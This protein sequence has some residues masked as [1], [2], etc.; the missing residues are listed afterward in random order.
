V[1]HD[2]KASQLEQNS[3]L[4]K[5]KSGP[6]PA[7]ILG[8]LAGEHAAVRSV[9]LLRQ[10]LIMQEIPVGQ[11]HLDA[12][13]LV[14]VLLAQITAQRPQTL[15]IIAV[16][17][18]VVAHLAATEVDH[19]QGPVKAQVDRHQDQVEREDVGLA[20][21]APQGR[22]AVLEQLRV[23]ECGEGVDLGQ[24]AVGLGAL[25]DEAHVEVDDLVVEPV[26]AV[27][28]LDVLAAD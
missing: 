11:V 14:P 16:H 9:H 13:L 27:Q 4:I 15:A 26:E 21:P 2:R 10:V 7:Q 20:C 18:V 3:Y 24:V 23:E 6:S 25:A 22:V 28:G 5:V 12:A 8:I 17:R 1:T 19:S